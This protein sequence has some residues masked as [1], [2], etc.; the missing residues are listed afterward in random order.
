MIAVDMETIDATGYI[1]ILDT[2]W[3][4]EAKAIIDYQECKLILKNNKRTV[5]IPC[6]NTRSAELNNENDDKE[7]EDKYI[8]S[9]DSSNT[10]DDDEANFIRLLYELSQQGT[11]EMLS[12]KFQKNVK[13]FQAL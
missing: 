2:D 6:R 7:S 10:D 11:Y 3:L 9:S 12:N 1:L 4:R 5:Q 8:E 13:R